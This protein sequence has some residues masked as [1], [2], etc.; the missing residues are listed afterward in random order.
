M[1][2]SVDKF[3]SPIIYSCT[4]FVYNSKNMRLASNKSLT[5][6]ILWQ[7][8]KNVKNKKIEINQGQQDV[9]IN[10]LSRGLHRSYA[11]IDFYQLKHIQEIIKN[12]ADYTKKDI[13]EIE[14]ST[15]V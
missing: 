5:L 11:E 8:K 10:G 14:P 15:F 2:D 7:K 1:L 4:G 6:G 9:L 12:E 13:G 3:T